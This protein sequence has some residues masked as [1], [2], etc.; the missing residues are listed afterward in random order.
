M[1][2]MKLDQPVPDRRLFKYELVVQRSGDISDGEL[3]NDL[4]SRVPITIM[5]DP[6]PP[7]PPPTDDMIIIP[8]G[9]QQGRESFQVGRS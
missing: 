9:S 6:L 3:N 5:A 7:A 8:G 2:D 1:A 4:P